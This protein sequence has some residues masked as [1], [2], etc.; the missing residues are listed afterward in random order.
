MKNKQSK[1]SCKPRGKV[2]RTL[3]FGL[4]KG[5]VDDPQGR[6][7]RGRGGSGKPGCLRSQ[8]GEAVALGVLWEIRYEKEEWWV[9]QGQGRVYVSGSNAPFSQKLLLCA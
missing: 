4:D 9:G 7:P 8:G 1:I 5:I 3:A 2:N 6:I